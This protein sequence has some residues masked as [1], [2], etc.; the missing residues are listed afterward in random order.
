MMETENQTATMEGEKRSVANEQKITPFLWFNGNAEEAVN[1]YSSA[2]QNCSKLTSIPGPNGTVMSATFQINGQEFIAFNGGS[3]FS[4]SPA[5]SFFL[6]CKT[7]QEIDGL[8]D[9]L[10]VG[11]KVFMAL[12]KYPFSEKYGWVEDKFGISWQLMLGEAD[13][14]ISPSLMF[15]GKQHGKAEEAIQFYTSIF[16]NSHIGQIERYGEEDND[17]TGTIMYAS[18]TLSGKEFAAMDSAME[19]A[20]G[21]TPAISLF[22]KCETQDE[23]DRFWEKLSADGEKNRCGW[24]Q[25]KFGVSWQIVPPILGRLL[26]N[27]DRAKANRVM[28]AMLKMDKI[29]IADLESAFAE[30]N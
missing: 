27:P 15:V 2:I 16:Q 26:G 20:F 13:Q 10:S 25:D 24:L 23:I 6:P 3:M 19:H 18:F 14:K 7:E 8:W 17:P 12:D 22:V 21:F 29:I 30:D 9:K 4:F 1:F 28:D 11:G 5:I